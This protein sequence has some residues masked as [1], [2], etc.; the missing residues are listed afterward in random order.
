MDA[1]VIKNPETSESVFNAEKK[2]I[3]NSF[4]LK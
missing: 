3:L 2:Y 4:S 1:L